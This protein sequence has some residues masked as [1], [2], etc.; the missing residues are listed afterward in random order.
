MDIKESPPGEL[1]CRG[2]R[3]A[4]SGGEGRGGGRT[5]GRGAGCRAGGWRWVLMLMTSV[6]MMMLVI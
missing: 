3:G 4:G 6:T 5:G 2:G 1:V